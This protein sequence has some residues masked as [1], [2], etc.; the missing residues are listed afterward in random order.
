MKRLPDEDDV[1]VGGESL[2]GAKLGTK[3]PRL[4]SERGYAPCWHS[5]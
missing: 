1:C 2:L 5:L 4:H 3:L